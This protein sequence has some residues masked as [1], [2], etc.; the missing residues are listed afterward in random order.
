MFLKPSPGMLLKGEITFCSA[1]QTK[2][3]ALRLYGHLSWFW[4]EENMTLLFK[5]IARYLVRDKKEIFWPHMHWSFKK[6]QKEGSRGFG[7]R[8]EGTLPKFYPGSHEQLCSLY[9][10]CWI[11]RSL[12]SIPHFCHVLMW[13][14]LWICK[15][16]SFLLGN[17]QG[18][19]E[20]APLWLQ[21]DLEC[22]NAPQI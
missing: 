3:Q 11:L 17:G 20:V 2:V 10:L 16:W 12:S 18:T 5:P 6:V 9:L 8:A 7:G 19:S 4:S 21:G 1:S 13:T 15:T 14:L 22:P